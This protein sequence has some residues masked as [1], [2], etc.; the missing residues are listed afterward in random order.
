MQDD[1]YTLV[2]FL[3]LIKLNYKLLQ[4]P[5]LKLLT[6]AEM[7]VDRNVKKNT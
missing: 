6:N 3:N 2:Q 4:D 7:T 1:L 5:D